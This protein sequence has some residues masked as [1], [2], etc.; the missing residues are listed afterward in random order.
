MLGCDG[1]GSSIMPPVFSAPPQ[2]SLALQ[3]AFNFRRPRGKG[4]QLMHSHPHHDPRFPLRR[5]IPCTERGYQ[6]GCVPNHR[7]V[8][9]HLAPSNL[10]SFKF[11][12]TWV[13]AMHSKCC[14][15]TPL[16]TTPAQ[17]QPGGRLSC[18]NWPVVRLLAVSFSS[19]A[20]LAAFI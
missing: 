11:I 8:H 15:P 10:P 13:K 6:Q 19:S 18:R 7:P 12:F 14:R 1:R 17:S 5:D 9:P 3:S 16:V 20:R 4:V 2:V